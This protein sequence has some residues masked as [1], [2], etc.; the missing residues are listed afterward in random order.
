M[1]LIR[2]LN[3]GQAKSPAALVSIASVSGILSARRFRVLANARA[4]PR[5]YL[6]WPAEDANLMG[7]WRKRGSVL[8][9]FT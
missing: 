8:A 1:A 3:S 5:R 2:Q 6:S 4:A 7:R 9:S